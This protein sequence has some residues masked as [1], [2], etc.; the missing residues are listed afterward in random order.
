MGYHHY[1]A[2]FIRTEPERPTHPNRRA[3]D[4]HDTIHDLGKE[5]SSLSNDVAIKP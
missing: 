4:Q 2:H 3:Y 1:Y 5:A